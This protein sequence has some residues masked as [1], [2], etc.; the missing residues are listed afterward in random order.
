MYL[1]Q[2]LY[3][4]ADMQEPT[5]PILAAI[6]IS[7]RRN[8]SVLR[9]QIETRHVKRITY[10]LQTKFIRGSIRHV[11]E[12]VS[13]IRQLVVDANL[14]AGIILNEACAEVPEH[15]NNILEKPF[16]MVLRTMPLKTFEEDN[17]F[18][19]NNIISIKQY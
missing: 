9:K 10:R 4:T 2:T 3:I 15:P 17:S 8:F 11:E 1:Q 14:Y 6:V 16:H 19:S 7:A 5:M 18:G 13:H 12:L